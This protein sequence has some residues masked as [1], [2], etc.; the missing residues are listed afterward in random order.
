MSGLRVDGVD[1]SHYQDGIIGW[2]AAKAAGVQW[3]Y[4]KA[5]EGRTITDS[6]YSK[7]RKQA[8][9]AGMP[10]GAYH[11]ARPDGNDAEAE[12][13]WFL[14]R[15]RPKPG[16]LVPMLDL[17]TNDGRLS[18]AD[19]TQWVWR[20]AEAVRSN[21]G[22]RPIV[23]T[24][25]NL[26]QRYRMRLWVARYSDSNTAP[27]VPEPW[28]RWDIWQFSDGQYGKPDQVA[29]FG[30]VDLNVMRKGLS[31]EDLLIPE[32]DPTDL[33]LR[34]AHISMQFSDTDRQMKQDVR[35]LFDRAEEKEWAWF[36][37]TEAGGQKAKPL[38]RLLADEAKRKGYKFHLSRSCWVAVHQGIVKRGSWDDGYVPVIESHEGVSP[39][40]DR[41]IAWGS[42]THR[43]LGDIAVGAG[44]YLTKGRKPGDPHYQLNQRYARA[45]GDWAREK[46]R[47]PALVFYHG[48]QNIVDRTSDTF[49]GQP[50]TSAWDALKRYENTGHGNIDVIAQYDKDARTQFT[51]VRALDDSEFPL[52]TDHF[53]V[54]ATA[55]VK[56]LRSK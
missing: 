47:G 16:D 7:R 18:Q 48:D 35:R 14:K 44:H 3:V 52:H 17:E 22:V 51:R 40:T 8:R 54:E 11:F 19:L 1:I 10:F 12:A 25:F 24:P 36:T 15:A 50:L 6:N 46:G 9:Q 42:F 20:F 29:G 31:V 49:F 23:Y 32:P 39:H 2:E 45:I 41:G 4:H 30:H 53:L 37:G 21:C 5:T 26:E 43:D 28:P 55:R 33:R 34:M 27:R 13:Q 56:T 38:P